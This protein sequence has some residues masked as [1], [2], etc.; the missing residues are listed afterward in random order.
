M[1][2]LQRA[3]YVLWMNLEFCS[4]GPHTT[5]MAS[6]QWEDLVAVSRLKLLAHLPCLQNLK[7][8]HRYNLDHQFWATMKPEF[9]SLG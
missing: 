8:N 3:S 2:G 1:N 6:K 9:Y 5:K 4:P 7:S